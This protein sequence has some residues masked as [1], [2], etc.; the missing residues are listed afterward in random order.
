[1]GTG[2]GAELWFF[3]DGGRTRV[4]GEEVTLGTKDLDINVDWTFNEHGGRY[5][6]QYK[7]F[8]HGLHQR[9]SGRIVRLSMPQVNQVCYEGT[10]RQGD[11][12]R[13]CQFI[14]EMVRTGE[15]LTVTGKDENGRQHRYELMDGVAR[16][17]PPQK[18]PSPVARQ[19]R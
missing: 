16:E 4:S 19:R 6:E 12:L 17:E 8:L 7:V 1:M 10:I 9:L 2:T 15:S 11:F 14:Q 3:I 18:R 13:L 5:L